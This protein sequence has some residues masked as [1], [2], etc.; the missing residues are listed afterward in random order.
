MPEIERPCMADLGKL[1]VEN[2]QDGE[3]FRKTSFCV[4]SPPFLSRFTAM[5]RPH[6]N[7]IPM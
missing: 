1:C 6:R 3:V 4:C 5:F 7:A 2:N